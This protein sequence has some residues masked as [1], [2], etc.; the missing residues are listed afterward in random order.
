MGLSNREVALLLWL[1]L[2]FVLLSWKASLLPL[3][4]ALA[5]T[6]L[7]ANKLISLLGLMVAYVALSIWL[8][9][10]LDLWKLSQAKATAIW[11]VTFALLSVRDAVAP[12]GD[13]S[14][15]KKTLRETISATVL[16]QFIVDA[17]T[18]S[19]AV[20]IALV[21]ITFASAMA[22]SMSKN[23]R[24]TAAATS[25]LFVVVVAMLANSLL[26][27]VAGYRRFGTFENLREFLCPV[28]LTLLLF[29][30]LFCL[31]VYSAYENVFMRMEY[32]L[33]T[34]TL[35]RYAKL[36]SAWHFGTDIRGLLRW[37]KYLSLSRARSSSEI[38]QTTQRVKA[39]QRRDLTPP[40]VHR[41]LGWSPGAA[42]SFLASE[43]LLLRD[44]DDY[45]DKWRA[46]SNYLN[47]DEGA[48]PNNVHYGVEGDAIVVKHLW[49]VLNINEPQRASASYQRF[50]S[51]ARQLAG[52]AVG[53]HD[54]AAHVLDLAVQEGR[55][56]VDRKAIEFTVEQ[57]NGGMRDGHELMLTITHQLP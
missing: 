53:A 56:V 10:Y 40:P 54:Q 46:S 34:Q 27:I 33:P 22:S 14:F 51:I 39:A 37:A 3:L 47:L 6:L 16:V 49:L 42:R 5:S 15:L 21:P 18:F 8:L 9:F 7:K 38:E 4:R 29:P 13:G 28:L 55:C 31:N 41:L 26:E 12:G 57:W 1:A 45:G 11:F 36:H 44:Y 2:A 30:F 43:G 17:Y 50:F 52:S 48:L 25:V 24:V 23:A 35:R 19:L 32:S 20:E